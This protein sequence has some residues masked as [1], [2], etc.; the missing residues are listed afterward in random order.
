MLEAHA[1][2]STAIRNGHNTLETFMQH[3]TNHGGAGLAIR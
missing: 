1:P 3:F 2:G